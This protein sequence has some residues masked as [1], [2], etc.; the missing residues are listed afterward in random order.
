VFK[1][2]L[3]PL[4]GSDLA[5]AVLPYV[6]DIG[7]RCAAEVVL[8]QVV[9]TSRERTAA[10]SPPAEKVAVGPIMAESTERMTA[11]IHP[12]YR[13][14]EMASIRTEVR[15]TLAGVKKRLIKAG[16]EVRVEVVFGRPA[17]RIVEYAEKE[18]VDLLAMATHGRTG[19]GR[20]VFGSVAEKVLRA[21][22]LP[23]LLIRPP[24]AEEHRRPSRADLKRL[25]SQKD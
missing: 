7:K 19:V 6:E 23:I 15:R 13:E 5:E 10:I 14:Q 8:L 16:L 11:A 3:V 24:G 1:K 21:T 17:V 22:A 2:V 9:T 18:G 4:D 20:W 12:V 25:G